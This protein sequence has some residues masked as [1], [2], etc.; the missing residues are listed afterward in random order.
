MQQ[1]ADETDRP[2]R[3]EAP[4]DKKTATTRAQQL[5]NAFHGCEISPMSETALRVLSSSFVKCMTYTTSKRSVG[6]VFALISEETDLD[7]DANT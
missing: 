2:N 6:L 1:V 5:P 7:A 3:I 4:H